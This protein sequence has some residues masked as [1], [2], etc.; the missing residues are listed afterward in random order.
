MPQSAVT[1]RTGL[2]DD[3]WTE[4]L[5]GSSGPIVKASND[6]FIDEDRHARTA[7]CYAPLGTGR[8]SGLDDR[9]APTSPTTIS[10]ATTAAMIRPL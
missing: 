8:T 3:R 9:Q 5:G 2:T 10:P 7:D 4:L 6:A 1:V